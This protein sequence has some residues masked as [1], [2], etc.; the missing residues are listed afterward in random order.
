MIVKRPVERSAKVEAQRFE[1]EGFEFLPA[2]TFI[3]N[4]DMLPESAGAVYALLL[5]EG[6]AV[7]DASGYFD[8][9]E[10]SPA[11]VDGFTHMYTGSTFEPRRRLKHHLLGGLA[12]STL[13]K[14]LFAIDIYCRGPGLP[15]I[16]CDDSSDET[17]LTE[18]MLPNALIAVRFADHPVEAENSLLSNMASPMNITNRRSN[19]FARRLTA[20][21]CMLD[22]KPIPRCCADAARRW[23]SQPNITERTIP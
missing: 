4:A 9:G 7:L 8:L 12:T 6:S 13:R 5:R 10:R 18:W 16:G 11:S 17:K 2:Q 15:I 14:T 23:I 1:V 22:G 3:R 21:R 20:L 19:A